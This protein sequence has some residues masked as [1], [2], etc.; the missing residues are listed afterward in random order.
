M[1]FEEEK[2][3]ELIQQQEYRELMQEMYEE[4]VQSLEEEYANASQ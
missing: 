4:W 1:K 3:G 2:H